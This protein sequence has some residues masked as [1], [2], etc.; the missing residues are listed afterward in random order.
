LNGRLF[1]GW[2]VLR[3]DA[4]F[5]KRNTGWVVYRGLEDDDADIFLMRSKR[6]KKGTTIKEVLNI[7]A[8]VDKQLVF[9]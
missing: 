4:G 3:R 7:R 1:D 9:A 2:S 8:L 6:W 5:R